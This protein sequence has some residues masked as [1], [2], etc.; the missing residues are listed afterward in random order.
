MVDDQSV[1]REGLNGEC[2]ITSPPQ[3]LME[4]TSTTFLQ[5]HNPSL[6]VAGLSF[7]AIAELV[8]SNN[9]QGLRSFLETHHVNINDKSEVIE[10]LTNQLTDTIC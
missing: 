2:A 9:E 4:N 6:M 3:V 5:E 7:K 1:L 10:N 8:K